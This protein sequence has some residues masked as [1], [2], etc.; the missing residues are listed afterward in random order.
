MKV[1]SK[2]YRRIFAVESKAESESRNLLLCDN[3]CRSCSSIL[4]ALALVST[5][6]RFQYRAL[7]GTLRQEKV[8]NDDFGAG[9]G[10]H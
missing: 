1:H 2:L 9:P 8:K 3:K 7:T 4:N 10:H 5:S 6:D